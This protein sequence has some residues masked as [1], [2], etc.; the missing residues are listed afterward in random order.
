MND[1]HLGFVPMSTV[2]AALDRILG[3]TPR[4]VT[5]DDIAAIA[6]AIEWRP[7][8]GWDSEDDVAVATKA[9]LFDAGFTGDTLVVVD[10]CFA[11]GRGA[12]LID[13]ADLRR[14]VSEHL[15][16]HGSV[17]FDG[18]VVIVE[19]H[20]SRIWLFHHEGVYAWRA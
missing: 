17:L 4:S 19:M 1:D 11:P 6:G 18:D 7:T 5:P 8:A 20:G 12:Y 15:G 2:L 16:R 10:S 9:G 14:F 3:G 13:G